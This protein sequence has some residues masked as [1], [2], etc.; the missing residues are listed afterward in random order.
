MFNL[1]LLPLPYMHP[2]IV[3]KAKSHNIVRQIPFRLLTMAGYTLI[4]VDQSHRHWLL[5]QHH[6]TFT[7]QSRPCLPPS[8]VHA[9]VM[10]TVTASDAT[11][12]SASHIN[13]WRDARKVLNVQDIHSS[14]SALQSIQVQALHT[15]LIQSTLCEVAGSLPQALRSLARNG[16]YMPCHVLAWLAAAQPPSLAF[17]ARGETR[18]NCSC[19][20]PAPSPMIT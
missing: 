7:L 1:E 8:S 5:C 10:R 18:E 9:P 3:T 15:S 12:A 19:T 2:S 20:I 4:N 13:F 17:W 6:L 11:N 16:S 14:G